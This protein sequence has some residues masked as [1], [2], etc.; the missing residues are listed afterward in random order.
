MV[1]FFLPSGKG[2]LSF[3]A[4]STLHQ[5]WN[6]DAPGPPGPWLCATTTGAV[7]PQLAKHVFCPAL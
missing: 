6:P 1:A 7:L 3:L 4:I 5:L 2:D